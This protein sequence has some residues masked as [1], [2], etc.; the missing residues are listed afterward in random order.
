MALAD[1]LKKTVSRGRGIAGGLG[2]RPY[3][4]FLLI[5]FYVEGQWAGPEKV[6]LTEG[7][8]QPPRVQRM[9]GQDIPI[10]AIQPDI[11]NIGK[12]T[13]AFPGGGN[14]LTA[15]LAPVERGE[16]RHV[17]LVGPECPDGKR[18]V[19]LSID[20]SRPLGWKMTVQSEAE[21]R[22]GITGSL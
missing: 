8:G 5:D 12:F 9:R 16:V 7:S 2:F 1:R 13:P 15:W 3:R 14:D 19:V 10:G 20:T 11:W 17:L 6:E 18:C 22:Q 4:V 21:H